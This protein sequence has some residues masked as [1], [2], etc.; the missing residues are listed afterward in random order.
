MSRIT[1]HASRITVIVLTLNE[2]RHIGDCLAAARLLRPAAMLVLDSGSAD[3][4]VALARAAGARVETRP[5][6]GY[7]GQRNA[8]LALVETEWVY[9]ID[10]DERVTPEQAA[11]IAARLPAEGLAGYWTPRDN[12]IC[13]RAVRGGGW[14]PDEQLRL[15]RAAAGRYDPAR[16]VHELVLLDGPAGH[17]SAPLIHYNYDDWRQFLAKQ[18]RY[19]ARAVRDALA[20]GVAIRPRNY[21]LQPLRAFRRRYLTLG[22]YRDGPLGLWLALILAYYELLFYI[23]LGRARRNTVAYPE[24]E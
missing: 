8:A 11:E 10:A 21:I 22:G 16:Q 20:A 12:R 2:A 23:W 14:W 15:F 13:G 24:R 6:D 9:F 3:E 17:L 4:T 18:R 5:F 7:A 19:T 1:H